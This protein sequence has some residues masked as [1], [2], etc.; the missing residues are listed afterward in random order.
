MKRAPGNVYLGQC[1]VH[2]L[3]RSF[4]ARDPEQP[5]YCVEGLDELLVALDLSTE[6]AMALRHCL[7]LMT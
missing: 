2:V 4:T 3:T 7:D 5:F 1:G 6:K